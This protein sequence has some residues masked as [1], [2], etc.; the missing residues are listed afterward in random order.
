[1]VVVVVVV[2][3]KQIDKMWREKA[4]MGNFVVTRRV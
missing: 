4:A 2:R 3:S 1:M